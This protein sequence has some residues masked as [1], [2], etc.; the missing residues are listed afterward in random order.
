MVSFFRKIFTIDNL[1]KKGIIVLDWCYMCKRC[2]ESVD[3]LLLY[4]P[5]AFEMWSLVLCLFGLLWVM[6][7]KVIGLN[8]GKVNSCDIAI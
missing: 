6:P 7:R 4:C 2:E 5:I 8:L 3:H 1:C